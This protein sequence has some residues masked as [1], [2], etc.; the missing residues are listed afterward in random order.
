MQRNIDPL[1]V[2]YQREEARNENLNTDYWV[3]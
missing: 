1:I 2:E 3:S